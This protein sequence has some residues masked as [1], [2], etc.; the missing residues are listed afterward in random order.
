MAK[1]ERKP[2]CILK[3]K[4]YFTVTFNDQILINSKTDST[5]V[6]NIVQMCEQNGNP[7]WQFM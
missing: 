4:Q 1:H 6:S 7:S 5:T 3:K 2:I